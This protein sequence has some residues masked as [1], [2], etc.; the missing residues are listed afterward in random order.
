[1][2]ASRKFKN[3]THTIE[4]CILC[5]RFPFLYPRNRFTGLHYNN[6]KM[7]D[8][9]K[10]VYNRSHDFGAAS[11]ENHF[12]PVVTNKFLAG[13]CSVVKWFHDNPLQWIHCIPNHTELDAMDDGWRKT[14]GIQMCKEIKNA[15]LDAGGKKAL[16]SYRIM[17]IKEKFGSLRFYDGG[18]PNEVQKIIEKY[19]YI[20]ARTCICCGKT[21]AGVSLGWIEPYCEECAKKNGYDINDEDRFSKYGT[22]EH[23]WYGYY[24]IPLNKKNDT[25]ETTDSSTNL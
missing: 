10:D 13:W 23:A 12:E 18:S 8:Y 3:I 16:K 22:E 17:Q 4:S 19:E 5:I 25:E 11:R 24:S 6:W 7:H 20:S 1:M 2:K 21:A 9:I 14:F 15:L